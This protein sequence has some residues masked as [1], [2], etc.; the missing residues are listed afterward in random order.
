MNIWTQKAWKSTMAIEAI[1]NTYKGTRRRARP[2]D[3]VE[4]LEQLDTVDLWLLQWLLRYPFQR[5]EDLALATASSSATVYRHLNVLHNKGLVERVM[6][7]ALGT[8]A[9]RLYHLNNL[10]LHVLSVHEQVD[11]TEMVSKWK[12]DER[13]LLRLLP[14]LSSLIT[15]QECINGLV[16]YA[17]EALAH[18]GR[19]SEVRW[20]WV[21]D[22]SHR[23]S[24]REK[25][26]RCTADAALLLRVRLVT[27]D[28]MSSQEQWYSLIVLLDAVIADDTWLIQRLQRLL[29]YRESAER[30]SVYQHFPPVVV[31][32]STPRR[33]EH[34]QWSAM[35]AATT[36]HVS[37]LAGA[38]VCLPGKQHMAS[39]NPWRLAWKTLETGGPC[40]LHHLLHSL[41]TE[42]I[43]PGLWDRHATDTV[44]PGKTLADDGIS[45]TTTS[46][47]RKRTRIIVG[48][49]MDRAKVVQKD[50]TSDKNDER[51]AI[52]F[53][54]LNLGRRHL[55]LLQ[56]LFTYPLLHAR[57]VVP[58]LELEAS[59]VERYLGILRSMSCIEPLATSMGQRWRVS[60][61]GLH[62]IAAIHHIN[63][64]RI[65]IQ[66][67]SDNGVN[68]VQQGVDVLIS[69]LE[70]TAGIYGSFASLSQAA[71]QERLL[72]REHRLLWWETGSVCERR[73]RDHDHWHNFRPDALAEYQT[74]KQKVRFWLEWD[75]GTMTTQDLAIKCRTY[76]H[77][78]ASRE[79][80]KEKATLP[81]L[82][83]V[84][85]E[86]D[87]E[88]RFARVATAVLADTHGFL[89][90]TTTMTRLIEEGPLA[91]IW[92]QIL[93]RRGVA[94]IMPRFRFYDPH[95]AV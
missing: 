14:R 16:M 20:H 66:H 69:H 50:H 5:A 65:A 3:P 90:R 87:Q 53:L 31:L 54:G 45:R 18:L 91:P 34:W 42:A 46:L 35:E 78:V 75:R 95:S 40:K 25:L 92:L 8:A 4:L 13:G 37:P 23:F 84:T 43:P 64:Q 15:V 27:E 48:N 17:P 11:P 61:R 67:E 62:L 55:D 9:C 82:L 77:Y 68:L 44:M 59:S 7:A 2:P 10:G 6:P 81:F 63:I 88:M 47:V 21:R 19:R 51:E 56:L 22:Y 70:H 49:Y 93:P 52:A 28:K 58:L 71:S 29:C 73:Y 76:A 89:I 79:W 30:W 60:E 57:E 80:F 74:G 83:I 85:P 33:M 12:T 86:R 24:Y 26:M 32:V 36:L 94:Q 72:G 38:I 39:Y 1:T 41:P